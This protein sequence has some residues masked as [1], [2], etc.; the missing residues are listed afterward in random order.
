MDMTKDNDPFAELQGLRSATPTPPQKPA[1]GQTTQ[2]SGKTA[3]QHPTREEEAP[4]S[5]TTGSEVRDILLGV[6]I[7]E[8]LDEFI[9]TL[10]NAPIQG[11]RKRPSRSLVGYWLLSLG[12]ERVR[13]AGLTS[14]PK[15]ISQKRQASN[16]RT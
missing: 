15:A 14:V 7:D 1:P 8:E 2:L 9:R 11:T 10:E 13:N 5:T 16:K 6:Y 3:T 4:T 12:M